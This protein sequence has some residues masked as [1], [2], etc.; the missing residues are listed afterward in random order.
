MRCGANALGA[1]EVGGRVVLLGCSRV[2]ACAGRAAKARSES[3]AIDGSLVVWTGSCGSAGGRENRLTW[4]L[5]VPERT[6]AGAAEVDASARVVGRG[7]AAGAGVDAGDSK[8]ET[9]VDT[10][11]GVRGGAILVAV[12]RL[13]RQDLR[14]AERR[15]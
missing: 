7:S 3:S 9:S 5:T 6:G 8:K 2:L 15:P 1:T 13:G 10:L 11:R 14:S 12:A 4:F